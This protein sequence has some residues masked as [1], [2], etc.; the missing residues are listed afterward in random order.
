MNV[1]WLLDNPNYIIEHKICSILIFITTMSI[2][3][4][5]IKIISKKNSKNEKQKSITSPNDLVLHTSMLQ[6]KSSNKFQ[7]SQV[8]S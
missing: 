3:A 8:P 4:P 5:G 6:Y 7:M 2:F 1:G